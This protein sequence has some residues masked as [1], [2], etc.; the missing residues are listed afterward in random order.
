[1]VTVIW[2]TTTAYSSDA[3]L[4]DPLRLPE[5]GWN[6]LR[7]VSP[8]VLELTLVTTKDRDPAPVQQWNFVRGEGD[9]RLPNVAAFKVI[10]NGKT[11]PV[12]RVGFKR[13]VLYA[14][15]K[16]RDLRIGNYL[17]LQLRTP[18][19]DN[20]DVRVETTDATL[21]PKSMRFESRVD[22][23]RLSPVIHVNQ[24]GYLPSLPKKAMVGYFLGS[25]G[26]LP[27]ANANSTFAIVDA[28][29]GANAYRGKLQR[30]PDEGYTFQTYQHVYEAD[31]S[32]LQIP[33]E[34]RLEVP[35][36]GV[37]YPFLI[38][39]GVAGSFARTYALGLYHQRCGTNN[40]LPF[41]RFV[42]GPCHT[43]PAEVP[44]P[45][46]VFSNTWKMIAQASANAT[47]NARH[48]APVLKSEATCLYPFQNKGSIDVSGGHHDAGDYSKYTANSAGLIHHL[49]TA[50]DVMPG[51]AD[52][53]N[54]GVPESGD[55]KGDILQ[56]AKWE[57]DFLAKMQD[58]D[59]G[60]YFL[61]YPRDRAYENNVLPDEGDP[62][63]VWP[64]TTAATAAA[65]AAL[66]QC[67]S[68]QY[69]KRQFPQSAE[70]Y[71][72]KARKGWA[73]LEKAIA[74]YGKQGAYQKITHYGDPFMHDD[75]LAWAACELFLATKDPSVHKR[76][77]GWLN[78][79]DPNI[80]KWSWWR[81]YEAW[82]CAIRSYALAERA[83]K[84]REGEL[85]LGLL[86]KCE[87]ELIA[88]AEDHVKR[89][90][91]SA[92]GTSF[93]IETK[94]VRA[95]GWYFGEDAAFDLAV[96]AQL[97]YPEKNDP[98]RN[99]T[100]AL[101]GNLN[102]ALGCNPVDVTYVTGLGWKRQRDIVH[103]YA[104]NDDRVLPPVGIPLG[105]VQAGFM[106]LDLYQKELGALSYP[107][108]GD[109]RSPYPFYDRW[110]DSHNLA[111]EFVI[112]H[113]GRGLAVAGWLIA[114]TDLRKQK[115]K[116]EVA[117][118]QVTGA[119]GRSS[120]TTAK[121]EAKGLE[122]SRARI[123][124]E[125]AQQE[126]IFGATFTTSNAVPKWIEAEAQLPDGRFVFAATNLSSLPAV[127]RTGREAESGT[128]SLKNEAPRQ[129]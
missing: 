69:M 124:W 70:L 127:S 115:W 36:L 51:V 4:E 21:W 38:D 32:D 71:L 35:G 78:P 8:T 28:Q 99:F 37:S 68:S 46:N 94:R 15:L 126:P 39:E 125:A 95:A 42:H 25:L 81:L 34:Y 120:A 31:F 19:S 13:R 49:M 89:A 17:Y 111:Q 44:V 102:Y 84:A 6:K 11:V 88:A 26:E 103:H 96:A 56:E 67:A 7:V 30:R 40:V 110:G 119:E 91:A 47:N 18:L 121:L 62:Q 43:A 106:W 129:P 107:L 117:S 105:N 55:G 100:D 48:T 73:F 109:Q 122:L 2:V 33:G 98:R 23:R 116:P 74:K 75:E 58:A 50:V 60:F 92:Y 1:L 90:G 112:L 3:L 72:Q 76:L 5:V 80:R 108:D 52:L 118:I 86:K 65:V 101:V 9:L 10:G 113:Q 29:S 57:A 87:G 93:P 24:V 41:T 54:L 85:D 45:S 63:V 59:G 83:G 27:V 16:K 128:R 64:K 114:Q 104:Q 82:G 61:V 12:E 22:P 97:E 20:T 53:D 14:P 77:I 123:V 66:A 79:A